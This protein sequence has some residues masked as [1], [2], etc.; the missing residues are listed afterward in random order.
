M[1]VII[2][3]YPPFRNLVG[4][5]RVLIEYDGK[6][7]ISLYELLGEVIDQYPAIAKE[8]SAGKDIEKIF[9]N[10]AVLREGDL[11]GLNTILKDGDL[12]KIFSPLSGG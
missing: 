7:E 1:K 11:L 12:L 4:M 8:I 10:L 5:K 2:D 3:F 6:S 9:H